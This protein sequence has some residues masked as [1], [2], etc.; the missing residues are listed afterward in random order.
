MRLAWIALGLLA[1]SPA[2]ADEPAPPPL[3]DPAAAPALPPAPAPPIQPPSAAPDYRP[4]P[5]KQ[6]IVITVDNDRDAKNIGMIAGIAGA[7]VI[8]GA[9][10]VY[11]NLDSRDAANAVSPHMATNEP[12]TSVQQADYDRAHN[13]AVKAGIFYGIGGAALISAVVVLIV[14]APGSEQTVIHAHYAA[15]PTIAPAPGGAVL[16]GAWSF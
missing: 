8:L 15:L 9:I 10:G 5:M 2:F 14:T 12:W 16:G 6:P 7:G 1:A 11:Y 3:P 13:S 4:Q